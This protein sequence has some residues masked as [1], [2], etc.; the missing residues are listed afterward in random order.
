MYANSGKIP[1]QSLVTQGFDIRLG[2]VG[3][4]QRVIDTAREPRVSR[5]QGTASP[6][7]HPT[8]PAFTLPKVGQD[9]AGEVIA[10]EVVWTLAAHS[11]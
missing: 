3:S 1:F 9:R 6:H 10:F 4:K 11:H 8:R 5:E 7:P 2:G